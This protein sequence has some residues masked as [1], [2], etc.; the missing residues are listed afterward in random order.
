MCPPTPAPENGMARHCG[1][2]IGLSTENAVFKPTMYP[3]AL[4]RISGCEIICYFRGIPFMV[5]SVTNIVLGNKMS[6][7]DL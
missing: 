1:Y 4:M 2:I 3:A 6:R 5:P 7:L